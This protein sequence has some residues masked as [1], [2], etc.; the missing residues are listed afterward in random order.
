MW[1]FDLVMAHLRMNGLDDSNL[2][3]AY[4]DSD[5]RKLVEVSLR[6]VREK[7]VNDAEFNGGEGRRH[8]DRAILEWA[9]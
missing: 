6:T 4:N 3:E 1:P 5:L 8:L 2:L 9:S 7:F